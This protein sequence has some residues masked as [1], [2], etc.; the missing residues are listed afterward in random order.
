M[1]GLSVWH[2]YLSVRFPI[3]EFKAF[4]AFFFQPWCSTLTSEVLTKY[5]THANV[6]ARRTGAF[7]FVPTL[8]FSGT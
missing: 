5:S 4:K 8:G 1:Y 6:T 3:N 2:L 7:C